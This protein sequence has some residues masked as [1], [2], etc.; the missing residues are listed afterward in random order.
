MGVGLLGEELPSR[1]HCE[2]GPGPTALEDGKAKDGII[3]Q[4]PTQHLVPITIVRDS[5]RGLVRRCRRQHP[6]HARELE[7]MGGLACKDQV[8][9][10]RRIKGSPK[11]SNPL[12]SHVASISQSFLSL[13]VVSGS[14]VRVC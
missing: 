1:I 14:P 8:A 10:M 13:L 7:L 2:V 6:E 9:E 12:A 3:G 5:A 11:Q 4:R